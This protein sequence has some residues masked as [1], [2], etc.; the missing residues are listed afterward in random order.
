MDSNTKDIYTAKLR[1]IINVLRL[2][3]CYIKNKDL[4]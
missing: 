3:K 1:A 2:N 4:L